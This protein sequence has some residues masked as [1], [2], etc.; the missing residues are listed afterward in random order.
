MSAIA[1]HQL[2]A[3]IRA[4]H[5]S[6]AATLDGYT[7]DVERGVADLDTASLSTLLDGVTSFL[8][9]ELLPHA[10]GEERTLYPALDPI[11]RD[12]GKPT[13]TM[14][15]DHEYI[16]EHARRITE[17]AQALRSSNAS[18]RASLSQRLQRELIQLQGLFSVHLAKE[19]RVYLPLIEEAVNAGDQQALL[20]ALHEEAE[21]AAPA[22]DEPLDVRTL[23]PARRHTV[24]FERFEALP[25]GGSFTIIND[26]DPKPLRYQLVAEYPGEL[27][28]E[29]IEQGPEVWR[30]RMGKAS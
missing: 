13:A 21:T 3:A 8:S 24:I 10:Q 14:S 22:S 28:W 19:E 12:R 29:Y 20:A 1:S 30:V 26:H 7:A 23:P 18:D 6:L 11:I 9:G 27:L 4:H 5:S 2:T 15:I 16:G 17:I 25:V